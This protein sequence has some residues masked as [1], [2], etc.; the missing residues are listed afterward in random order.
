MLAK[1]TKFGSKNGLSLFFL[2]NDASGVNKR[3]KGKQT[4]NRYHHSS[5]KII[6]RSLELTE[7]GTW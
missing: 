1:E 5:N 7:D 2:Y 4:R 6:G 3:D